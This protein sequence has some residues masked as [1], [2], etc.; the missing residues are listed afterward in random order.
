MNPCDDEF[1]TLARLYLNESRVKY[2]TAALVS[3][4]ML[5]NNN[6]EAQLVGCKKFSGIEIEEICSLLC[7]ESTIQV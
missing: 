5:V 1:P 4:E 2:T 3:E 7:R 6:K